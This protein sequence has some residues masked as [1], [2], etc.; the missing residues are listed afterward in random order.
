[1]ARAPALNLFLVY[2]S[3]DFQFFSRAPTG[4][5]CSFSAWQDRGY[6]ESRHH[7][8]LLDSLC[9][10]GLPSPNSCISIAMNN[11]SHTS[12]CLLREE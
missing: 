7:A 8:H 12:Q 5:F 3:R 2:Q 9:L 10:D 11:G 1:M 6:A 4:I